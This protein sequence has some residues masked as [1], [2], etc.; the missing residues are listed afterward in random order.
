[1]ARPVVAVVCALEE[2]GIHLRELLKN[3]VESQDRVGNRITVGEI[4]KSESSPLVRLI[5]CGIGAENAALATSLALMAKDAPSCVISY[6]CAGSHSED[7][8][9]GDTVIVSSVVPLDAHVLNREGNKVFSGFRQSLQDI[10][11]M[12]LDCDAFLLDQAKAAAKRA[13]LPAW[14]GNVRAPVVK[15][16]KCGSTQVWTQQQSVLRAISKSRGTICEEMEAASVA[17]CCRRFSVPFI[18]VKDISNNELHKGTST[19]D[20]AGSGD[21]LDNAQV[22]MR[23]AI[24]VHELLSSYK[25][26]S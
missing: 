20:H 21:I 22:G 17:W 24:I 6:G 13:A 3:D 4:D 12:T 10:P 18:A 14:P 8:H 25:V 9:V 1:M 2:E 5:I 11:V 7:L 19:G 26:K 23:A 15:T 16:G